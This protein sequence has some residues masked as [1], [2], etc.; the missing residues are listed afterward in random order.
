M[1]SKWEGLHVS[2]LWRTVYCKALISVRLFYLQ[3]HFN[4]LF[5]FITIFEGKRAEGLHSLAL[6]GD[7]AH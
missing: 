6:T 4:L 2:P 1:A 7:W 3:V 5:V